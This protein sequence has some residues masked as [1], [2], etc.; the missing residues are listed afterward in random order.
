[1]A[2]SAAKQEWLVRSERGCVREEAA[3][4]TPRGRL[5]FRLHNGLQRPSVTKCNKESLP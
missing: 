1:M 3:E 5:T 2:Q 4:K